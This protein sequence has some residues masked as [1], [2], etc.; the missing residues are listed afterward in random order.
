MKVIPEKWLK[1]MRPEDRKQFG[2]CGLTAEEAYQKFADRAEK[3][4]HKLIWAE[5]TRRGI[6]VI[7]SRMDR[8]ST[9]TKG[10]PDFC[11]VHDGDGKIGGRA[12]EHIGQQY[13]T[14]AGIDFA[15]RAQDI[16]ASS[17]HI[18]LGTDAD[19]RDI[20]L[21]PD[22]MLERGDEFR[23]E[24]AVGDKNH[25]NHATSFTAASPIAAFAAAVSGESAIPRSRCATET[26]R[27]SLRSHSARRSAT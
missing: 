18:V 24:P 16:L 12:A 22:D 15:D 9:T 20:R 4:L 10:L 6:V 23:G 19:R 5:L 17:L 27:P 1:L 3:D 14:L 2:K 25:S 8:K 26:W 11:F 7:H 13:D 21:R